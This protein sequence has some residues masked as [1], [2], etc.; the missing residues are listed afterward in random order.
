MDNISLTLNFRILYH[1][2]QSVLAKAIGVAVSR[3]YYGRS[4]EVAEKIDMKKTIDF[5][6]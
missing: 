3:A 2:M 1:I 6:D 5:F 4:L